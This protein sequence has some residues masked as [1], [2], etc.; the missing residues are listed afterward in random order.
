MEAEPLAGSHVEHLVP[1]GRTAKIVLPQVQ[2]FSLATPR[3]VQVYH[4]GTPRDAPGP[5]RRP[6]RFGRPE[7][8][9]PTMDLLAFDSQVDNLKARFPHKS[10]EEIEEALRKTSGHAGLVSK[11]F[12]RELRAAAAAQNGK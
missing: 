11:A 5:R 8:D 1:P 4:L 3:V 6:S 2:E 10:R 7:P 12:N 9:R